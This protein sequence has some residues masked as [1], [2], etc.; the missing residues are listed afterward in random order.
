MDG[1]KVFITQDPSPCIGRVEEVGWGPSVV[2]KH[3][4]FELEPD[5]ATD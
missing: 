5:S 3:R 4:Q 1:E 2:Q